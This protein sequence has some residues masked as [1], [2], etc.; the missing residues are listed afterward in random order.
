MKWLDD[1]KKPTRKHSSKKTSFTVTTQDSSP[2]L[3]LKV[4]LHYVSIKTL[5]GR[6]ADKG[7]FHRPGKFIYVLSH[8]EYAKGPHPVNSSKSDACS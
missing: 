4:W 3:H 2:L 1:G 7:L 5:I 6:G 8:P